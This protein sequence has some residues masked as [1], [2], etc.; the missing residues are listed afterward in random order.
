MSTTRE[1]GYSVSEGGGWANS[2]VPGF[3]R[4]VAAR[5]NP[6]RASRSHN[7]LFPA[8]PAVVVEEQ[9]AARDG[10]FVKPAHR[11]GIIRPEVLS[12]SLKDWLGPKI[13]NSFKASRIRTPFLR[14]TAHEKPMRKSTSSSSVQGEVT[15]S[16]ATGRSSA[17]PSV[18]WETY[19]SIWPMSQPR[20]L[21]CSR[22]GCSSTL[23]PG[24]SFLRDQPWR[25]M[26]VSK[27]LSCRPRGSAS[28]SL[29]RWGLATDLH[30]APPLF[31]DHRHSE[32]AE[33]VAAREDGEEDLAREAVKGRGVVVL[34]GSDGGLGRARAVRHT[35]V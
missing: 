7:G 5:S 8:V 4:A 13:L 20:G 11:V 17:L 31:V 25:N 28:R 18:R 32:Q 9:V 3:S 21:I 16:F 22:S 24:A 14:R 35:A 12:H 2:C 33:V 1:L 27:S 23:P 26:T 10:N 6:D 29:T 19:G 15:N 30:E 34:G